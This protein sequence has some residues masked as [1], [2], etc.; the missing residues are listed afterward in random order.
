M[1]IIRHDAPEIALAAC[2]LLAGAGI[3]ALEVT[4]TVPDAADLISDLRK[5]FPDICTGA[6]TVITAT[7]AEA[8]L[9][10]GTSFVVSPCW[11]EAAARPVR[12]AKI[13]YLPGAMTPGEV[14]HHTENGAEIVKV[15]P[16][17]AAGGPGFLNALKSIF[18]EIALMPTGGVTPGS[19][20]AYLDA[21]AICVG[22]GGNLLPSKALETGET[23]LA[24]EQIKTALA[25]VSLQTT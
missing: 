10:A 22:M 20:Q 8:V 2:E 5:R 12:D 6:G 24:R 18:P 15:F 23:D 9:L 14:L 21:G 16:A 4:M 17:D 11:S 7:Q 25:A 19:A 1:P 13:P 3:R